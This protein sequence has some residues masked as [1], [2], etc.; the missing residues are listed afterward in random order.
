MSIEQIHAHLKKRKPEPVAES[1]GAR[2]HNL[3]LRGLR[4]PQDRGAKDFVQEVWQQLITT[5][6]GEYLRDPVG[7][8]RRTASRVAEKLDSTEEQPAERLSAQLSVAVGKLVPLYQLVLLMFYRDRR[9]YAE[10][11][12][13]LKLSVPQVEHHLAQAKKK[14]MA[15][16]ET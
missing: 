7:Y 15:A 4:N 1:Y 14:L 3:L 13:D 10:I 9:S 12:Q 5:H 11:G 6:D 16:M 2:A 8:I